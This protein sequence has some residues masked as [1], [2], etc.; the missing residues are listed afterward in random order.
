MTA[1]CKVRCNSLSDP[2][3][4]LGRKSQDK[5]SAVQVPLAHLCEE[6]SGA[7]DLR[8][9]SD[10]EMPGTVIQLFEI[11]SAGIVH[12]VVRDTSDG[13]MAGGSFRFKA[14]PADAN[15][16]IVRSFLSCL[17]HRGRSWSRLSAFLNQKVS[18]SFDSLREFS[19]HDEYQGLCICSADHDER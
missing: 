8:A 10:A 5:V 3:E 12:T 16:S 17:L 15:S 6:V 14:M 1:L 7:D 18:V 13:N 9:L 2:W 19:Q 4:S 11:S